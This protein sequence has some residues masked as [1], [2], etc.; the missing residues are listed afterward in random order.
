V[1]YFVDI[2]TATDDTKIDL[3]RGADSVSVVRVLDGAGSIQWTGTATDP[4]VGA[5]A[6]QRGQA[7]WALIHRVL[8]LVGK[9]PIHSITTTV[10]GSTPTTVTPSGPD[11]LDELTRPTVG[12]LVLGYTTESG[13]STGSNDATH[14][15]DTGRAWAVNAKVGGQVVIAQGTGA[16]Q[17]RTILAN[18]ATGVTVAPA[19]GTTPD[20]TSTYTLTRGG[21]STGS[22]TAS[23]LHDTTQGWTTNALVGWRLWLTGGR[24]AD[25]TAV[26]SSNTATILTLA[27]AW[28]VTPD[29]TTTYTLAEQGTST[30]SNTGTTLHDTTRAWPTT[31][32]KGGTVAITAGTGAGQS[33]PISSNTGTVLT[34]TPAWGTVPDATSTYSLVPGGTST[35]G[36]ASTTLIDTTVPRTAG[37]FAG[38]TLTVSGGLGSGQTRT[39][40]SNTSTTFTVTTDWDAI[41]DNTSAYTVPLDVS[42]PTWDPWNLAPLAISSISTALSLFPIVTVVTTTPHHFAHNAQVRIAGTAQ[43]N[44]TWGPILVTDAVTFTYLGVAGL[45]AETVGTASDPA[46][47]L[48]QFLPAGWTVNT[49]YPTDPHGGY[50][51][52][53]PAPDAVGR[54]GGGIFTL[55]AGETLLAAITSLYRQVDEHFRLGDGGRELVFLRRD[56]RASGIAAVA[57]AANPETFAVNAAVCVISKLERVSDTSAIITAIHPHGAG[58]PPAQLTLALCTQVP[59]P[60]TGC[61]IRTDLNYLR[62][63]VAEV[64]YGHRSV[65]RYYPEIGAAYLSAT[66]LA[67]PTSATAAVL[68]NQLYARALADLIRGS[69][70]A[71]TYTLT[72]EKLDGVL[73]VGDTIHVRYLL[74]AGTVLAVQIDGDF[75]ITQTTTR[76]GAD[77]TRQVDLLITTPGHDSGPGL[78]TDGTA[79]ALTTLRNLLA[80]PQPSAP[81]ASTT[82]AGLAQ[83]APNADTTPGLAVQANDSRLTG[84]GGGGTVTGVTGTAPIASSGGTAPVISHNAT[85]TAGTY[86]YPASVTTDT[87]G[88]VSSVTGGSAPVSGVT[89]TAPIVSSGGTTPAISL[90]ATGTAGTYAS[91][92]SVTTD[93]QGRVSAITA[94][95]AP[96]TTVTATAPL[97]SSGGTTPNL[98]HSAIGTPGTYAYPASV[99]TDTQGHV[100]AVSGGSAPIL[101]A[102]PET[103]TFSTHGGGVQL[104]AWE[105]LLTVAAAATTDTTTTIPANSMV[106]SVGVYVVTAIP[107][108]TT[109]QIGVSGA[110]NRYNPSGAGI[111]TAAGTHAHN[112]GQTTITAYTAATAIRLTPNATPAAATGQVRVQ[113]VYIV[114]VEPTS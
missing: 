40:A 89:G 42:L 43:Y 114:G 82:T 110:A 108:A 69:T 28:I 86:A 6:G 64:S 29:A 77:G 36:N 51:T 80:Y 20:A 45:T 94:G 95:S 53:L 112:S 79:A 13:T 41:P 33:R 26:I 27:T 67:I 87:Q 50:A 92:S 96:V 11:L 85:G 4:H 73:R 23:T 59:A 105:E 44:G 90:A 35:G 93:A 49:A 34:V 1:S 8:T 22:N 76:L 18:T 55:F 57:T 109:F 99:T 58:F 68:A 38:G 103:F 21:T 88:H 25:Q 24:G 98:T 62:A 102:L 31:S 83:L 74:Y 63:V 84:G 12:N 107:T 47:G 19:W 39:V 61:I 104:A 46:A 52:L 17:T 2:S 81:A 14:L 100:S 106:L 3:V 54:G 113:V 15:Y 71:E 37:E 60:A 101:P 10:Q 48:A 78:A 97:V 75:L 91:P 56:Q 111:S 32:R 66:G 9:G 7:V 72:V 16:G 5:V 30:G 70:P 65:D